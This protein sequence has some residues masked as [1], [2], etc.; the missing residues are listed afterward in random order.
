MSFVSERPKLSGQ[1]HLCVSIQATQ[2]FGGL[3]DAWVVQMVGH[4]PSAWVVI[5][6][7]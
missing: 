6:G 4:L 2:N 7:S 5:S 3:R 1:F